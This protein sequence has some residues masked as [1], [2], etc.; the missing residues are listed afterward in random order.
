MAI[1]GKLG[2]GLA[3]AGMLVICFCL[4]GGHWAVM[5]T[6][7]WA[8]M[9]REYSQQQSLVK[10]IS[11]TF[12]GQHPCNICHKVQQGASQEKP[13]S[14]HQPVPERLTG[15][16]PSVWTWSPMLSGRDCFEPL[17]LAVEGPV[18]SPPVPPPRSLLS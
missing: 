4:A 17:F 12:D 7:A 14:G 11:D 8:Q 10:A 2:R 18:W 13:D 15:I 3:F 5:Q 6:V 9:L 16:I 1:L